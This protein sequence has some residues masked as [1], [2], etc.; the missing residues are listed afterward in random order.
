MYKPNVTLFEIFL[1]LSIDKIEIIF[2]KLT[3][4]LKIMIYSLTLLVK[5]NFIFPPNNFFPISSR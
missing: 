1:L 5:K 3:R 2:D 4:D